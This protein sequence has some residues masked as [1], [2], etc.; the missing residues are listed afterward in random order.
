MRRKMTAREQEAFAK[1]TV[2]MADAERL[3]RTL[4]SWYRPAASYAKILE[5][6]ACALERAKAD[7]ERVEGESRKT[8]S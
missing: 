8:T 4:K 6:I 1:V 3:F 2:T 5:G 7:S